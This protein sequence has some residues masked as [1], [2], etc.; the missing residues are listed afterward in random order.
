MKPNTQI[1]VPK[2]SPFHT[3]FAI[4]RKFFQQITGVEWDFRSF[5]R[6]M[7]LHMSGQQALRHEG[8]RVEAIAPEHMA[9]CRE[10]C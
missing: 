2:G 10:V 7:P 9:R 1:L 5:S 4:F 3:A 6:A 8:W